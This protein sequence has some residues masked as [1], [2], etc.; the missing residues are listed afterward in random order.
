MQLVNICIQLKDTTFANV[1]ALHLSDGIY[2]LG[3]DLLGT[4][5]DIA[6]V[7]YIEK[8]AGI[9]KNHDETGKS[10]SNKP[11]L[12]VEK[13]CEIYK[14]TQSIRKTAKSAG[15]SEEKTKKILI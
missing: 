13:I 2:Y 15:I 4:I 3:D 8:I 5:D 14:E 9:K 6:F 12:S 1:G 11:S 10:N 7:N